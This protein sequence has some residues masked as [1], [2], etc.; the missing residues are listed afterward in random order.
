MIFLALASCKSTENKS[1]LSE[2]KAFT[3]LKCKLKAYN[4][5]EDMGKVGTNND[6]IVLLVTNSA[7]KILYS[8]AMTMDSLHTEHTFSVSDTSLF[9]DTLLFT[10]LEIDSEEKL[11]YF[12]EK[13]TKN[14]TLFEK[15]ALSKDYKSISNLLSDDDVL[16]IARL[17]CNETIFPKKILFS[18]LQFFDRYEYVL[19]LNKLNVTS[20]SN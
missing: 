3:Q 19:Y 2:K 11:S 14:I 7:Q 1:I 16:G 18:G 8:I 12:Q 13:I 10:L 5:S 4:L 20:Q 17:E 9:K 15:A 6:E